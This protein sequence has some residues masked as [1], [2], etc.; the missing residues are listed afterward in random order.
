MGALEGGLI[1]WTG[2]YS[3]I[4]NSLKTTTKKVSYGG[5]KTLY[6]PL[7]YYPKGSLIWS[8]SAKTIS[9]PVK[10]CEPYFSYDVQALP[11]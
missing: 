4:L 5:L 11:H 6:V 3:D 8:W 10:I 7:Q 2:P 9:Y 1:K